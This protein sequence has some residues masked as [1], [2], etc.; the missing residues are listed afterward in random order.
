MSDVAEPLPGIKAAP[1][2]LLLLG[3]A[4]Y[5]LGA[6][7]FAING[8]V[9]K[10]ILLSGLDPA[11]VSQ[12]RVTGA[13][14]ILLVFVA[15]NRP[16]RLKITRRELPFL[17]AYGVLGV[18]MTQYLYF[19]ALQYLPVGVA[20]LIEFT[21]PIFVTLWF[22]FVL[23]DPTRATVW[24]ALTIALIGLALVAE[25]WRGFTFDAIGLIAAL[26]AALALST[27]YILTDRQVR[28]A[29]PRDPVSL[30]MWGFGFASLFW[31]VMQPWWSFPWS[32]FTGSSDP[33]LG[34]VIGNRPL[35]LLSLWMIVLGT[36]VPF[37]LV[38]ASM[39]HLRASQA[40]VVG[41][42]EPLLAII[43]A[44]LVLS[45]ALSFVQMIG[46]LF[47]LGGV[48][49]AERARQPRPPRTRIAAHLPPAESR[50]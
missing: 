45:E 9:S 23:K 44:W 31:V 47:I 11:R 35:W 43:V 12:L 41:L 38:V 33:S 22:R 17:V 19:V 34:A 3:Y 8:T 46:G 27:Y 49:L 30:T 40:S 6:L 42:T 20:L 36:V 13:F 4:L 1:H 37:W 7:T 24:L 48:V 5:V 16:S 14:L 50:S 15:L 26:G 18:A 39:R 25:V 29:E 21:A 32:D 2:R 10:A 28:Q